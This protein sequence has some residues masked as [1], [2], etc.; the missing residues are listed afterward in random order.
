M[1]FRCLFAA[2]RAPGHKGHEGHK[3]IQEAAPRRIV[4]AVGQQD[5]VGLAVGII[6]PLRPKAKRG[7]V[8]AAGGVALGAVGIE[9]VAGEDI[10][11]AVEALAG[12]ALEVARAPGGESRG[13]GGESAT[14][15]GRPVSPQ[16][17]LCSLTGWLIP[18]F[19]RVREGGTGV[20]V[21][22]RPFGR[23]SASR[24]AGQGAAGTLLLSESGFRGEAGSPGTKKGALLPVA[25]PSAVTFVYA[26]RFK[27]SSL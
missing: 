4:V 3:G 15:T 5:E 19:Q 20:G 8:G 10:A 24:V 14:L 9:E 6:P 18:A 17:L 11:A 22:C 2:G 27:E 25:R 13:N 21:Q 23:P 1:Q 7:G 26:R 16:P 12:V